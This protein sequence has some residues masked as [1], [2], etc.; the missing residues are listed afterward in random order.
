M[1][2]TTILLGYSPVSSPTF[3]EHINGPLGIVSV[4]LRKKKAGSVLVWLF[5]KTLISV[6]YQNV[7]QK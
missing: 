7:L 4:A 1:Y 2:L 6:V 3:Q 5:L